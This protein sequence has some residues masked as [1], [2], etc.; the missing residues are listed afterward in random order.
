MMAMLLGGSPA[1]MDGW[2]PRRHAGI[3]KKIPRGARHWRCPA[4]SATQSTDAP[5][6]PQNCRLALADGSVWHGSSFGS[7]GTK[8]SEVV[9]NTALSGYQEILTDPSY[10]G[11]FVLMTNPQ[12]G[13]TGINGE[14]IEADVCHMGG[15]IIR[16]LSPVASNYRSTKTLG[17]YLADQSII[18]IHDLDTRAITKRL[19]ETGALMGALST[20]TS[21]SDDDL[22]QMAKN[23]NI[24]GKDLISEVTHASDFE[25]TEGTDRQWE[26]SLDLKE[27]ELAPYKVVALD[28]GVKSNILRRLRS[29]NCEVIVVP[30]STPAADILAMKPDG[31][32]LSNGPG[33]PSAVPYAVDTARELLGKVP[34][35]GICMGHQILGQAL[36]G[37]TFKL[38]FGH[39][40][41][42]HPVMEMASRKIEISS[43]NHNYAVDVKSLPSDV[44]VSH[45][46]LND[47]TC[48]GLV[49]K[50]R[51]MMSV[52]YHPEASPGPHDGDYLFSQ[53]TDMMR[54]HRG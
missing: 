23:E 5:W 11:Q 27:G 26:F 20:D 53:F 21:I 35:F 32:L 40:G 41:G 48:S 6:A 54:E 14:D 34:T 19:R 8:V 15:L 52:Q 1:P 12:I 17:E 36:G 18:G 24:D 47:G 31:I 16:Q 50:E 37:K 29:H 43:Q 9:F 7:T 13:N 3:P 4:I 51:K 39:H 2:A 22:V 28:F 38:K 46:N 25:W 30:A 49:S 10:N 45:I 42:N 44:Q 33:D